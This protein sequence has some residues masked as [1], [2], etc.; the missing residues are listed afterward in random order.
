MN[1]R[2]NSQKS[3]PYRNHYKILDISKSD[4]QNHRS[5]IRAVV[6]HSYYDDKKYFPIRSVTRSEVSMTNHWVTV[7]P[8]IIE[9]K[10]PSKQFARNYDREQSC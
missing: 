5:S 1:F 4:L 2:K 6:E 8:V 9:Q 3:I 7:N 10:A